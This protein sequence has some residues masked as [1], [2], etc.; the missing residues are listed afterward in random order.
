[1]N[2]LILSQYFPPETGAPQNRLF[3]LAKRLQDNGVK[4]TVLTSMPNYPEMV[5]HDKYIGK[6]YHF[7]NM[8]G[9][10]I[11]RSSIYVS[12]SK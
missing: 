5:I 4:V 10:D 8:E 3:D 12:K 2:L 7:E 6:K 9:L 11:H 1:M